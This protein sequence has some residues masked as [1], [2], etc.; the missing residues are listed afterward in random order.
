M[1]G[2]AH[3]AGGKTDGEGAAEGEA[4]LPGALPGLACILLLLL[5]RR[6]GHPPQLLSKES[7]VPAAARPTPPADDH[8]IPNLSVLETVAFAAQCQNSEAEARARLAGMDVQAQRLMKV[9]SQK[10]GGAPDDAAP[11]AAAGAVTPGR[12]Q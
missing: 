10:V 4:A 11:D 7:P 3:D 12:V 9:K 8:H 6:L 5:P 1:S 2:A